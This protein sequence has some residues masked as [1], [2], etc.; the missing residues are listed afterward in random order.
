MYMNFKKGLVGIAA[1]GALTFGAVQAQ[2]GNVGGIL[3]GGTN[4]HIK[5][6]SVYENVVGAAGHTLG[7]YGEVG[8][9][10]GSNDFCAGGT[11]TCELT[12]AFGGY[13][14]SA[15]SPTQV[16]F[17]GGWVRF[18]VDSTPDFQIPG[19]VSDAAAMASASDGALW[20]SLTGHTTSFPATVFGPATTGTLQGNGA[21]LGG[22]IFGFG[23][24]LL[25]VAGGGLADSVFDTDTYADG[26]GGTADMT[27]DTSFSAA[28]GVATGYPNCNEASPGV[29]QNGVGTEGC[30]GGSATVN[31][32]IIPEPGTLSI[33]GLGLL[34]LA[35]VR[36]RRRVA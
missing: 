3:L 23:G 21:I 31:S 12:F 27:L 33:L 34:G 28:G 24:G 8:L 13:T 20:L 9:V 16:V 32:N 15:I 4:P 36:R 18:Y 19:A 5:I 14:V 25:D 6:G 1:V 7:G 26:L 29:P 17:T 30:L 35:T 11:N 22:A 2:A 10:D